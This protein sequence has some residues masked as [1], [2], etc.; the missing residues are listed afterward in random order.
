MK[1]F[2][3]KKL[4]LIIIFGLITLSLFIASILKLNFEVVTPA[5][6]NSVDK[7]I[8]V[9]NGYETK[10]SFNTTSV[11]HSS[12]VNALQFVLAKMAK[13]T[14]TYKS[15]TIYDYSDPRNKYSGVVQK[16]VSITN[17]IISAYNEAEI[18]IDYSFEGLIIDLV[19]TYTPLSI[20]VF[21]VI[22]EVNGVSFKNEAEFLDLYNEERMKEEAYD[23]EK[24]IWAINLTIN[25]KPQ[26]IETAH[27]ATLQNGTKYPV[28]GLSY[29]EYYKINYETLS[30]KITLSETSTGG[31]S[32]GLMQAL[33]IFNALTPIDY[34]YG[35]KIAGTGTID[36]NG[37][38]GPIGGMY[39]KIFTAYYNQVD[40]FFVPYV[41][42]E[43]NTNYQ[44]AI[45]AYEAL[46]EPKSL[47]LVK[48]ST[49]DDAISYLKGLGE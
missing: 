41:E 9:E 10:G 24:G 48:V 36:D 35:L 40:V 12:H 20:N 3:I 6:I 18:P 45:K 8:V 16:N 4:P 49:I 5:A 44:D 46:G 15:S 38:V 26:T 1:K 21:D 2:L 11:Y 31:P 14:I 32:G 25:G 7:F 29:Y 13:S 33:A 47:K 17:S 22:S 19:Y 39:S 27:Y 28:Y 23:E 43:E 42:G 34:S 30:P 37:N